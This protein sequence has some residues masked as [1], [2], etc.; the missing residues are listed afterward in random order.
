MRRSSG[1]PTGRAT[2]S[3]FPFTALA[4]CQDLPRATSKSLTNITLHRRTRL[5][6]KRRVI[7]CFQTPGLQF[8]VERGSGNALFKRVAPAVASFWACGT[9]PERSPIWAALSPVPLLRCYPQ[10]FVSSLC[11]VGSLFDL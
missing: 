9:K 3:L 7:F 8:R 10:T 2:V 11:I 1:S 4:Y 5:D 6:E